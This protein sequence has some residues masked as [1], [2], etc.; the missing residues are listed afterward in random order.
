[1]FKVFIEVDESA[2]TSETLLTYSEILGNVCGASD[3]VEDDDK[4][5]QHCY[6][7]SCYAKRSRKSHCNIKNFS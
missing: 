2:V 5:G 1:M 7:K 4:K 3:D 6:R